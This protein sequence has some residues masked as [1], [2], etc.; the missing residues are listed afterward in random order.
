M[1][2]P[3][4]LLSLRMSLRPDFL[5]L[6]TSFTEESAKAFGLDPAAALKLTL[7]CEE[8]FTYLCR[9]G[10]IDEMLTLEANDGGYY[11][12]LKLLFNAYDFDPAAFNLTAALSLDDVGALDEMGLLIAARSVDR[13][14]LAGNPRQGLELTLIK[15]KTYPERTEAET[16]RT[17]PLRN[18]RFRAPDAEE[19]KWFVRL[20][21]AHYPKEL[22]LPAFRFPGKILDMI[23]GGKY[24][25]AVLTGDQGEV[26]GGLVWRWVGNKVVELFG[27][28]LFQQPAEP[29]WAQGLLDDCL[30]RIAKTDAIGLI[31]RYFTPE[32]PL[33]YFESLGSVDYFPP[34]AAAQPWPIYYRYL[35]EDLGCRVWAHPKIENFLRAEYARLAFAREI[36]LTRPEGEQRPARSVF[37]AHFNRDHHQVTLRPIWDG[38]DAAENLDRHLKAL[39]AEHL[40]NIFFEIDLARSW[41]ADLTPALLQ[42]RFRPRLILPYGGKA[43]VVVFQHEGI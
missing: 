14:H 22:Y 13:F 41:Q 2:H 11:I 21:V 16:F 36:V 9:T 7:A 32:L 4:N 17:G 20:V 24:Q 29:Q 1:P 28:Y 34:G 39:R 3:N 35:R 10:R 40:T 26:G 43:D 33:H 18:A 12:G 38:R 25:A 6:A 30:G 31:A 42:N 27:P 23:H 8:V 19:L 37:A 5:R 15:E